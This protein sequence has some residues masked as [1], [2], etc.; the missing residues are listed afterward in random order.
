M[1]N[2]AAIHTINNYN[3]FSLKRADAVYYAASAL[4]FT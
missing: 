3:S 1:P 4:F 2:K